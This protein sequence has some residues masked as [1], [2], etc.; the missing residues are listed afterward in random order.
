MAINTCKI[1]NICIL[2]LSLLWR[3][4]GR[5]G[6]SNHQ[7]SECLLNRS[8]NRRSKKTSKLRV[9][10]LCAGDVIMYFLI[11]YITIP[12]QELRYPPNW[13]NITAQMHQLTNNSPRRK[14]QCAKFRPNSG[15]IMIYNTTLS[16]SENCM[17]DINDKDPKW[18]FKFDFD[19]YYWNILMEINR[20]V[21]SNRVCCLSNVLY[22]W[23]CSSIFKKGGN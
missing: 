4:D 15:G 22:N 8:F 5:D 1:M 17:S 10:G 11:V 3:H 14:W 9:T 13:N 7:P 6:V 2:R 20:F 18:P 21:E 16:P 19:D 12:L 23:F